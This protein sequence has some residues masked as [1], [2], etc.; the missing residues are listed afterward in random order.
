[1]KIQVIAEGVE[2]DEQLGFLRQFGCTLV[3]GYLLGRSMPLAHLIVLLA[4]PGKGKHPSS[5]RAV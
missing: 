1:M 4:R 5:Y 3:Q 2:I